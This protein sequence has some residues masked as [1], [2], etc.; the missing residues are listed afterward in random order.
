[1]SGLD[2]Y[3][4]QQEEKA[5][6]REAIHDLIDDLVF[7]SYERKAKNK[8]EK[9]ANTHEFFGVA[10]E[11]MFELKNEYKCAKTLMNVLG[12]NLQD[13]PEKTARFANSVKHLDDYLSSLIEEAIDLKVCCG[14]FL[15]KF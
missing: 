11:E 1:M 8:G 9:Y 10:Y 7:F 2:A 5:R 14:K 3:R 4:Q 6:I 13:S 15:G 12:E